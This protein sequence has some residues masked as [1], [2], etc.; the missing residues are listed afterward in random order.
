MRLST[1][2]TALAVLLSLELEG[3]CTN[4][5]GI[6]R[7]G[8]GTGHGSEGSIGL[9]AVVRV[10]FDKSGKRY[11][12]FAATTAMIGGKDMTHQDF[13]LVVGATLLLWLF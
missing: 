9:V 5:M 10:E 1:T 11:E 2:K 8:S 4:R 6:R 13:L 7:V 3:L 12:T